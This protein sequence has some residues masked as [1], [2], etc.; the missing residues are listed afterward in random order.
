MMIINISKTTSNLRKGTIIPEVTLMGEAVAHETKLALL[1]I[2]LLK[3]VL[4]NGRMSKGRCELRL[5]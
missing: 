4:V 2:L 3:Y 1:D 5:G